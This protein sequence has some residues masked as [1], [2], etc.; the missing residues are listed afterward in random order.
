MPPKCENLKQGNISHLS[1][2]EGCKFGLV[3]IFCT[4]G[5]QAVQAGM[6]AAA[7]GMVVRTA[8]ANM[9]ILR[10]KSIQ[11]NFG[12]GFSASCFLQFQDYV[13]QFLAW[14]IELHICIY[15]YIYTCR[16]IHDFFFNTPGGPGE[17]SARSNIKDSQKKRSRSF[18]FIRAK[19]K[20]DWL[21]VEQLPCA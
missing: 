2:S 19:I 21:W 11:I 9:R 13:S 5:M 12:S 18:F 16:Y 10:S 7:A 6:V 1:E 4:S 17:D 8:G 20:I 3:F 15:I 14:L